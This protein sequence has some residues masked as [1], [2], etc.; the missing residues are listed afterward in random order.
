MYGDRGLQT[1]VSYLGRTRVPYGTKGS[2]RIDVLDTTT[3][4]AY[5]YKFG[6]T[7]L[8]QREIQNIQTHGPR[9]ISVEEVRP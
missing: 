8:T 1:E 6:R 4:T 3:N 9:G 7:G 5:D 2:I